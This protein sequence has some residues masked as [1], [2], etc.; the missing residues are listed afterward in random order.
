[1]LLQSCI[2]A[3]AYFLVQKTYKL[4]DLRVEVVCPPGE[5]I[6]CGAKDGDYFDLVGEMVSLPPGQAFSMYSLGTSR[7]PSIS[8]NFEDI[9]SD[10]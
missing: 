5:L 2:D 10:I 6:R 7:S 4:F 8:S 1:M 3:A 9:T